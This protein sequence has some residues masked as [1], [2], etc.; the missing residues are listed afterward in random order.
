MLNR[1][2]F[3]AAVGMT[4]MAGAALASGVGDRGA[5]DE[6]GFVRI[7]GI[8][9]WIAIQ[10]PDLGRPAILYLHG[11]PAEAQSPFLKAFL[12]WEQAFTV[13][14][15]DQR[16]SGKTYGLNGP[17]TPGMTIEQMTADAIEV[18]E[19]VRRRLGKRRIILV[20]QSWG[21]MLGVNVVARRPDLFG[22]FV[23][24]GQPVSWDSSL[25]NVERYAREQATAAGDQAALKAL[26]EAEKLPIDDLRRVGGSA[27]WRMAPSDLAYLRTVQGP[28]V[29]ELPGGVTGAPAPAQSKDAAD[30]VAGG[31]FSIPKLTSTFV[32]FDVAKLGSDFAL[33]MFVIQGR[34]D[35]VTSFQAAK[36]WIEHLHAPAK[37]F[38]PI[39]GGH[40]A[41]FT[42]ASAFAEALKTQVLPRAP[43]V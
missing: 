3:T 23:G 25:L 2:A 29:G 16:G 19:H 38:I 30:W 1:R 20:G 22:A 5:V 43:G 18:A 21:A 15:W 35:H 12:P 42:N 40:F 26:D 37:G 11:G 33:P 7:G 36:D 32:S 10:G 9:Q 8:D 14:N 4:A 17:S 28:F 13:A 6:Q 24:T 27:R 34:D 39:D 31:A 41:C